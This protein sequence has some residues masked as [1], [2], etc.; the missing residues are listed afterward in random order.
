MN[1]LIGIMGIVVLLSIAYAISENRKEINYR[2]VLWGLGLQFIFAILILKTPI[3]RPIFSYVDKII[4]KLISFA[5]KGSEFVFSSQV[6]NMGFH[7]AFESVAFRLLPTIIFFSALI[8]ILYH[9]KII[10]FVIK[11]VSRLMQ[12]TMH[13]SGPETLSVSANIFVGQTEAPLMIRPYVNKMTKSE[14]VAVMVG[15]FATAAGGVLAIYAKWLDTIPGIAGHLMSASV[16]SAPA[17][18]VIA[19]I[20]YPETNKISSNEVE[21]DSEN[22]SVNAMD[23]LGNGTIIGLKLAVNVG[24]MLISFISIIAL[25]NYFLGMVGVS[26]ESVLGTIFK[27]LAWTMGIPWNESTMVGSLMGKKIVFTE[28]VAFAD[29]RTLIANNEI[30]DRAAIITSYA[31][32]GFANFGSIGIQLGGIG[33]IAP[34]R[35]KDI[36]QLIFKAM[37][38]GALASWLTATLAGILI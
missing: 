19:K 28:F 6:D 25:L 36:A 21:L 10:Q 29:L 11:H 38:G 3:G 33:G 26:I 15:G 1:Q 12:K 5:D 34:N 32:C 31:L 4:S 23:A 18:L 2:T 7:P 20:I 9:Y 14:L 17:A 13:T 24:A 22:P 16:M 27:P 30:S 37:I 35:R 8:S